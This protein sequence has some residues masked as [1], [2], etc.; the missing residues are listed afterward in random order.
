MSEGVSEKLKALLGCKTLGEAS[1]RLVRKAN[2]FLPYLVVALQ[3]LAEGGFGWNRARCRR[4]DGT[5]LPE[6]ED[7]AGTAF[8]LDA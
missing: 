7:G 5:L 8:E 3:S 6:P 2:K 4:R 1:R